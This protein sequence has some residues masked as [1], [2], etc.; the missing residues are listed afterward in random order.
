MRMAM[1]SGLMSSL[2]ATMMT[3]AMTAPSPTLAILA[4]SMAEDRKMIAWSRYREK[5]WSSSW[6]MSPTRTQHGLPSHQEAEN[7]SLALQQR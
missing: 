5:G 2:L 4:V 1:L 7:N 6:L 3:K